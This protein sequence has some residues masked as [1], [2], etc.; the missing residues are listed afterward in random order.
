VSLTLYINRSDSHCECSSASV[1]PWLVKCPVC[2]E[3]WTHVSS[4]Y[5]GSREY[6]QSIKEMRPDLEP[7]FQFTDYY[8][9]DEGERALRS[10]RDEVNMNA[11]WD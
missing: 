8:E 9:T 6:E 11:E 10:L 3:T 2:K 4:D 5:A 1:D 7:D